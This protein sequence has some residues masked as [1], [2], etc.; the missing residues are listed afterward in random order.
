[1]SLGEGG[2]GAG[3]ELGQREGGGMPTTLTHNLTFRLAHG[4][5]LQNSWGAVG[6]V[7]VK[8]WFRLA[9]LQGGQVPSCPVLRNSKLVITEGD[10]GGCGLGAHGAHTGIT[11]VSLK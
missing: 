11:N 6:G 7:R 4:H 10:P 9:L 2:M 1:M 3:G 5:F 8:S